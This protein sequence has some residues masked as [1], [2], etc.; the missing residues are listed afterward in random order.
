MFAGLGVAEGIAGGL[1]RGGVGE[2]A[3]GA[4][5]LGDAAGEVDRPA[6]PVAG[7]RDC[8]AAGD[9]DPECRQF[10]TGLLADLDEAQCGIEQGGPSSETI[11]A[12]SPI[13]LTSLTSGLVTS[14]ATCSSSL[15]TVP[16]R[17]SSD[18]SPRRVKPTRSA[19]QTEISV[20]LPLPNQPGWEA[21]MISL[22]SW[23]RKCALSA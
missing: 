4:G 1:D 18:L 5:D 3:V 7:L 22:L 16:M 12:A 23:S 17:S 19:K 14:I 6:E 21:T 8:R 10:V 9:A 11:I 13:S 15:A 20:V 2:H